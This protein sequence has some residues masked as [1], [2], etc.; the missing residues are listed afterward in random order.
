MYG[1]NQFVLQNPGPHPE[2]PGMTQGETGTEM[3]IPISTAAHRILATRLYPP[4][5]Y[6]QKALSLKNEMQGKH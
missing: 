4:N 6:K 1:E 5:I 3:K 2:M